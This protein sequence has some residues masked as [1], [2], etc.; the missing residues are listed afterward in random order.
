MNS[1]DKEVVEE[2]RKRGHTHDRV[3]LVKGC[4]RCEYLMDQAS[5]ISVRHE[6]ITQCSGPHPPV[7]HAD[8]IELMSDDVWRLAHEV[9]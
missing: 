5:K 4:P 9:R 2:M 8:E 7:V 6:P 3:T 1:V